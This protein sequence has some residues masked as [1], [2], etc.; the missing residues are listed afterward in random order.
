MRARRKSVACAYFYFVFYFFYF[1]LEF[2]IFYFFGAVKR[3]DLLSMHACAY[4]VCVCVCVCDLLFTI[5]FTTII[6]LLPTL[7]FTINFTTIVH[8][9][10]TL[11]LYYTYLNT[12]LHF[13]SPYMVPKP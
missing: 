1:F 11:Q 7:L 5:I 12:K 10:L 6:Y 13:T 8:L 4:N 2:F 9:L 3:G